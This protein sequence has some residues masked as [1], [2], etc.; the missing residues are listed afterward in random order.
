MYSFPTLSLSLSP[1]AAYQ[2]KRRE[3]LESKAMTKDGLHCHRH[4]IALS[5]SLSLVT[6][7]ISTKFVLFF[8]YLATEL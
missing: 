6:Q 5:L 8:L 7:Q 1:G 2:T 4:R 3:Q